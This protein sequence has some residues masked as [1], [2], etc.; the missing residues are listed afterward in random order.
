MLVPLGLGILVNIEGD[1]EI[2]VRVVADTWS[3]VEAP[4]LTAVDNNLA[5]IIPSTKC[6]MLSTRAGNNIM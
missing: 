1:L 6:S 3:R 5:W 2:V 4:F